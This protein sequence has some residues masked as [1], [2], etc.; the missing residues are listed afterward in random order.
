MDFEMAT[1]F[2]MSETKKR[3][4][5]T[6]A[7]VNEFADRFG[8]GEKDAFVYLYDHEGIAFLKDNYDI[9][10]TLSI[11][12]AVEDLAIVCRKNGGEY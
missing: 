1:E 8:L 4:N 12:E 2:F 6:V 3:I 11:E 10:H 5:Y 9:E 7:C